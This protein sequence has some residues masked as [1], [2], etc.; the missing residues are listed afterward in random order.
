MFGRGAS[1]GLLAPDSADGVAAVLA[2][3]FADGW[4]VV[5]LGAATWSGHLRYAIRAAAADRPPILLSTA[6]LDRVTEHEPADLVIGVQA[7]LSMKR[8]A[9]ELSAKRQW[10][11]LDPPAEPEATIGA[12]VSRADSG[13]LRTMHGTP[14]DTVL[15]IEV[16]TGDGRL[17]RFGGRVVK[18]V[19]GYDG[20]RLFTGSRGTLGLITSLYVRV[21][22]AARADHTLAVG[23]GAGEDGLR[24]GAEM[25]LAIRGATEC[26][27]LELLS[28]ALASSVGA[29]AAWTLLVRILG[30]EAAVG[31][32]VERVRR[33][34]GS[35]VSGAFEAGIRDAS[36]RTWDWLSRVERSATATVRLSGPATALAEALAAASRVASGPATGDTQANTGESPRWMLAAHAADGVIRMWQS[37]SAGHRVPSLPHIGLGDSWTIRYD[38]TA[39]VVAGDADSGSGRSRDDA[40]TALTGRLRS[41]FDPGGILHSGEMM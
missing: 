30:S 39:E 6:R 13:P 27:A 10:L 32:G 19:A 34:V 22:G 26:D 1:A 28:P 16:A 9:D 15:G 29:D 33:A 11:P 14:R 35:F 8:L 12:V 38:G 20:V 23:C 40:V 24:R 17:L 4:P 21:R 3:C 37:G 36:V 5:P 18:N 7:G 25:A 41:V 2:G 31:E